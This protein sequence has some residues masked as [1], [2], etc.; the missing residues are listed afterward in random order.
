MNNQADNGIFSLQTSPSIVSNQEN[1]H[2]SFTNSLNYL[3][4]NNFISENKDIA[5]LNDLSK[6]KGVDSNSCESNSAYLPQS[7]TVKK[8]KPKSK[9]FSCTFENCGKS[10][11]YKWILERHINSHFCFKLFKC[12]YEGCE[13]AYKSK[14][15]LNLHVKNKH[16]NIKPY[17]CKFC[18][19]QF[20]HRNGKDLILTP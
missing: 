20:S 16:L 5:S 3:Q 14:E 2:K 1:I 8:N 6:D 18:S 9:S 13:K 17:K 10:F 19:L 4:F 15:N 7:R 11:D 12:D